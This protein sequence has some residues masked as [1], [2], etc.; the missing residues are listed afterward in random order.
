[1]LRP[2]GHSEV[3]YGRVVSLPRSESES[4]A[5]PEDRGATVP[6]E[7]CRVLI[8]GSGALGRELGQRLRA[9]GD[10][11]FAV[12]RTPA[13]LPEGVV[14]I[15]A[16]L[17]E[18][19]E[20]PLPVVDAVIV[21]LPPDGGGDTGR[22]DLY[23]SALRNLARALAAEPK[24]VVFVSSTRVFEGRTDA[25][26]L[27]ERDAPAPTSERG[28][29]LRAGEELA[30]ELWDAVILRPAGIYGPGRESLI[31][32]VE[33]GR[34]VAY[35]RRTN[36]IHQTDLVRALE[37]LVHAADPPAVLHGVDRR[38]ALLGEVVTH[39]ARR[40]GVAPPPRSEPDASGRGDAAGK[41]LDGAL[42]SALLGRLEYPTF[43]EGYDQV[44]ELRGAPAS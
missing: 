22:P 21:T 11:V 13:S 30:A 31:R 29:A 5:T 38:P 23:Q 19:L 10:E 20:R 40:L 1:M 9:A 37:M 42:L 17:R 4:V 41:V 35:D 25:A 39:I 33:Q 15:A 12:R 34:P 44:I 32:G 16:D 3:C 24:R 26:S 14:G 8:A 18:P 36:R 27:T 43:V 7:S 28:E 6:R 2:D